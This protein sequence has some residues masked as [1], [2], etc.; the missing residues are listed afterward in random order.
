MTVQD[1]NDNNPVIVS[2]ME[3]SVTVSEGAAAGSGVGAT[4]TVSDADDGENGEVSFSDR[5][6]QL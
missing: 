6:L 4:I 3:Q 1:I 5:C 2:V